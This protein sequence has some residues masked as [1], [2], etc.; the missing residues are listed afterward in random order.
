MTQEKRQNLDLAIKKLSN[1][2]DLENATRKDGE[3]GS[4]FIFNDYVIKLTLKEDDA[5][6]CFNISKVKNN[7]IINVYKVEKYKINNDWCYVIYS[8]KAYPLTGKDFDLVIKFLNT[9]IDVSK[10]TLNKKENNIFFEKNKEYIDEI[11]AKLKNGEF[12][13]SWVFDYLP[14][15]LIL[16][17]AS[18]IDCFKQASEILKSFNVLKDLGFIH[19]DIQRFNIMKNK[20]GKICLIDYGNGQSFF[21]D[22][23]IPELFI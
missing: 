5:I 12:M 2:L 3:M 9:T 13:L 16:N 22:N 15:N 21:I 19:Q 8:E 10:K 20:N 4:A 7:N 1:K 14:E 6:N 23:N 11:P 17:I 18:E